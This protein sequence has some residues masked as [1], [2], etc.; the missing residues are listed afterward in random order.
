MACLYQNT[1]HR[2]VDSDGKRYPKHTHHARKVVVTSKVWCDCYRGVE[3]IQRCISVA[4]DQT[5]A[6]RMLNEPGQ[7]PLQKSANLVNPFKASQAAALG[8]HIG[9]FIETL[10]D[11]SRSSDYC[12]L[13]KARVRR[14]VKGWKFRFIAGTTAIRVQ[15]ELI[16]LKRQGPR[17]RTV[18]HY[19]ATA[20]QF[21]ARQNSD[22][23]TGCNRFTRLKGCNEVQDVRRELS[24]SETQH[25]L[26]TA[27]Q[28]LSIRHLSGSGR[29]TLC[30]AT[31]GTEFRSSELGSLTQ[32]LFDLNEVEVGISN[33]RFDAAAA[34]SGRGNQIRLP[35]ELVAVQCPWLAENHPHRP[36]SESERPVNTSVALHAVGV[37]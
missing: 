5:V 4:S 34:K 25:L 28:E 2:Y 16:T 26:T 3:G 18:N 13:I 6:Q 32:A 29:F 1:I 21:S 23:R 35:P 33:A 9:E 20:T 12:K 37:T 17:Q 22:R 24:T 11:A 19:V 10:R 8:G 27:R 7:K 30:P 14:T 31:I 15:R 36:V